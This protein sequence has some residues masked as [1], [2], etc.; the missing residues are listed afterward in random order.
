MIIS[1]MVLMLGVVG[2]T[3]WSGERMQQQARVVFVA[4]DVTADILP[5][6]M[7][8]IEARLVVSQ[9][10]EGTMAPDVA[11]KAFEKLAADY[12]DRFKYWSEHPPYGL[13]A[14]LFGVQHQQAK[15]FLAQV[16]TQVLQPLAAGDLEAARRALPQVHATYEAHRAGVDT[17]VAAST[18]FADANAAHFEE[19]AR[20][21]VRWAA[22]A[23]G[24]ALLVSLALYAMVW[25]RLKSA[26]ALPLH[27]ACEAAQRISTGDLTGEIEVSG[28]DE[29]RQMLS[30]L[31]EMQT[32]LRSLIEG[33]RSGV[34]CLATASTQIAQGNNDLSA[35]TEAQASHLQET[36]AAMSSIQQTV[37]TSAERAQ[38]ANHLAGTASSVAARGGKVVADVVNSMRAIEQTS[39]KI[40][41]IIGVI[42]A[43]A[44]QTNILALNAAVEAARAGEQ[45]RGFAVVAGE[46]RSLAQRCAGAAKEIKAL[47]GNSVGEVEAGSRLVSEA[48]DTMQEIVCSVQKV[49]TLIAEISVATGAQ[50]AGIRDAGASIQ[51]LD[52]VTQQNAALVEQVAAASES[53]NQQ[54]SRLVRALSVFQVRSLLGADAQIG[55]VSAPPSAAE[56]PDTSAVP[57]VA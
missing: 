52:G 16:R 36:A 3:W 47:I 14:Q 45:G 44:F 37:T 8:L 13:Q 25:R 51:S 19:V 42:D 17:T 40:G 6:P 53:M 55:T 7:Y 28:R 50:T 31:G 20:T 27:L 15:A 23:L 12:E 54:T 38:E 56:H 34:D 41:D 26:L 24:S 43:I 32:S 18:A 30:R 48:G 35:R 21:A 39:K 33:V 57:V 29:A 1:A 22:A 11:K 4:K 49:S 10:L 2:I 5:P 9:A 46:V